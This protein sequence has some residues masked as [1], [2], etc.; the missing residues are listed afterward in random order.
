MDELRANIEKTLGNVPLVF[1]SDSLRKKL[2][3]LSSAV[4][5]NMDACGKGPERRIM[6]GRKVAYETDGNFSISP[7]NL[8]AIQDFTK[9]IE[10]TYVRRSS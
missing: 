4:L 10:V 5:S 9:M 3:G 7:R 6:V 1:R 8:T 2:D